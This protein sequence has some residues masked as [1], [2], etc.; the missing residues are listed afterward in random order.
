MF[1]VRLKTLVFFS[2]IFIISVV[3]GIVGFSS[4]RNNDSQFGF[5][6]SFSED[7]RTSVE[8][9][10]IMYHGLTKNPSK[11]NAY[12]IPISS[13]EEDL[14]YLKENGY[15]TVLMEDVINYVDGN[16]ALPEKPIVLTFD[17]GFENNLEYGLPLLE[18][19]DMKAVVSIVGQY[20]EKFSSIDDSNPEYAYLT[21]D[22]IKELVDNDRL[23]I[24]N[25]SY[26]MHMLPGDKNNKDN[27]KGVGQK[28]GESDET[29]REKFIADT[30]KNQQLLKDNCDITPVTYAYPYGE[31]C[32]NSEAILKELGYRATLSCLQKDNY[33][34]QGNPDSLFCL[35]RY[36]RSN[37]KSV[38]QLLQK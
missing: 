9:P 24:G 20:A 4:L 14:K 25:H 33:I 17:D 5:A 31:M 29:Y 28:N 19:Y 35:S 32:K 16:E 3:V 15:T 22:N 36:L 18:K 7:D 2:V 8:L 38:A 13:F 11:V 10:I 26:N 34:T 27:R 1:V 21:W 6:E 12:V 37:T 23:E 30:E